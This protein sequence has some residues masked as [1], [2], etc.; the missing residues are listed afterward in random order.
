MHDD[1]RR[2][3]LDFVVDGR[4]FFVFS[5]DQAYRLL[6]DT[7]VGS[8]HDRDRLAGKTDFAVRQDR[9]IVKS[10]TVIRMRNDLA[11]VIDGNDP[12]DALER[13]RPR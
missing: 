3:R 10:G 5:G 13:L 2:H 1:I 4:Q 8:K 11:D 6:G 7:T 12:I 9:L